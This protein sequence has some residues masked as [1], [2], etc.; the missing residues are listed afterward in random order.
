MWLSPEQAPI[1]LSATTTPS[2]SPTCRRLFMVPGLH[3]A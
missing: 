1:Q 2:A 3:L